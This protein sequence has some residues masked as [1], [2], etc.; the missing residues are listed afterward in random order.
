MLNGVISHSKKI[1][2]QDVFHPTGGKTKFG[3]LGLDNLVFNDAHGAA[4]ALG[5]EL[6]S[7]CI[8]SEQ[9]VVATTADVLTWVERG[10]TLTD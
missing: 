7:T 9:G 2:Q 1:R 5:A 8:E 4:V 3:A 10:S 6:H